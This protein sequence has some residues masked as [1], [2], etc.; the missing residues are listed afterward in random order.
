MKK[1]LSISLLL[2]F[3]ACD[4][5]PEVN[6]DLLVE[7]PV[8]ISGTWELDRVYQN[9][10]DIT[11]N[12]DFGSFSL[13]LNYNGDTP[14]NY[15]INASRAIPFITEQS[16]GSWQFD[17]RIYPQKI[18]FIQGDT[19]TSSLS[20]VLYPRNNTDLVLGFGLG[21]AANIYEYHLVKNESL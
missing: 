13:V 14:S 6:K 3:L 8:D 10:I 19:A 12:Y 7:I 21:C 1:L 5:D 15:T 9:E 4:E 11:E 18:H 2:L 16:T 17:N 20:Q